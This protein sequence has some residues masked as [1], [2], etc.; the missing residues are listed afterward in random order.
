VSHTT[1]GGSLGVSILFDDLFIL[2]VFVCSLFRESRKT[3]Q[4]RGEICFFINKNYIK[5]DFDV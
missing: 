2:C 3:K 1:T 5:K 4:K